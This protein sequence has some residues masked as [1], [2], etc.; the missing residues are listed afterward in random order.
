[1]A[2][3]R[4]TWSSLELARLREL[5]PHTSP[6]RLAR[7]L[8]RSVDSVRR[9]GAALFL[10]RQRSGEWSVE[11]DRQLREALGVHDLATVAILLG[12]PRDQIERRIAEVAAERR[13]GDWSDAEL[14]LLRRLHGT[15][16]TAQLALALSREEHDV[17]ARAAELCLGKDKA[18]AAGEGRLRMPRW[19]PAEV[20][21]LRQLYP[22]RENLEIAR[23]LGRTVAS[24]TNKA[25]QLGLGKSA[26]A[27]AAMGRR[28]VARRRR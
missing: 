4:G 14:A 24:V 9:R 2:T 17:R 15:R 12:R 28:N 26:A 22:R 5:F 21:R 3:R 20:A 11:D 16:T 8:G 13:A 19:T 10:G 6:T 18:A 7:V 25:S 23:Q 1:M 27:L